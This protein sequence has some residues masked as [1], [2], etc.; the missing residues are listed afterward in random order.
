MASS[1]ELCFIT[2]V[3]EDFP[4][5]FYVYHYIT[6]SQTEVQRRQITSRREWAETIRKNLSVQQFQRT[7]TKLQNI[8]FLILCDCIYHIFK[9]TF[10]EEVKSSA[11]YLL[12][13]LFKIPAEKRLQSRNWNQIHKAMIKQDH[14]NSSRK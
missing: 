13:A 10:P 7:K 8:E 3:L 9:R 1:K 6:K 14:A 5:F 4:L 11:T 2:A 12:Y